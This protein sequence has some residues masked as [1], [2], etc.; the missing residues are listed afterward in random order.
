MTIL[1]D[2]TESVQPTIVAPG[3]WVAD[4]VLSDGLVSHL[5]DQVKGRDDWEDARTW[6]GVQKDTRSNSVV[7]INPHSLTNTLGVYEAASIAW[8]IFDRF[9]KE[10]MLSFTQFEPWCVNRYAIGEE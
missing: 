7:T 4:N 5:S 10:Y 1:L 8:S 6:Q 3:L 2:M 9:G